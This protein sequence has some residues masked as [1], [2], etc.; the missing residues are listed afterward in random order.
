[1]QRG[2]VAPHQ[3]GGALAAAVGESVRLGRIEV[4]FGHL[5]RRLPQGR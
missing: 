2:A 4:G 3:A 1:M 5:L